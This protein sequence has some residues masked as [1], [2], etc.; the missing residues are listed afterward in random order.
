MEI[1]VSSNVINISWKRIH[2][3]GGIAISQL[4]I[5]LVPSSMKIWWYDMIRQNQSAKY[6][7]FRGSSVFWLIFY[8]RLKIGTWRKVFLSFLSCNIKRSN[9]M[10]LLTSTRRDCQRSY[11][12]IV[13][14]NW[15]SRLV[16]TICMSN[17]ASVGQWRILISH[18]H[19]FDARSIPT[20][21][22]GAIVKTTFNLRNG[23]DWIHNSDSWILHQ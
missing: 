10:V 1:Q 6:Q 11:S 14:S 9:I 19:R 21:F 7:F 4:R 3:S 5:P 15:S 12:N 8:K 20:R 16:G 2:T 22:Y 17:G 18:T 13:H 23:V